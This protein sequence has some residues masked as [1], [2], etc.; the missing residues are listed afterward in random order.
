MLL[1]KK[2][3]N[4]EPLGCL[5]GQ[6]LKLWITST[7]CYAML[8]GG[9]LQGHDCPCGRKCPKCAEVHLAAPA[10]AVGWTGNATATARIAAATGATEE[11]T[12]E[13]TEEEGEE[14]EAT[15][16]VETA[17]TVEATEIAEV[18]GEVSGGVDVATLQDMSNEENMSL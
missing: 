4:G 10:L 5:A 8:Q 3:A 17:E 7:I 14:E 2:L 18:A 11:T 13:A 1:M 12:G 15:V 6:V 9:M 16:A